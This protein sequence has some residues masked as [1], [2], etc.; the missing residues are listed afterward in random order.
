MAKITPKQRLELEKR[1]D[2]YI[3]DEAGILHNKIVLFVS[4]SKVPLIQVMFVLEMTLE[5]CK[6]QCYEKYLGK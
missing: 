2:E 5:D 6:R 4:E 1:Y 3:T